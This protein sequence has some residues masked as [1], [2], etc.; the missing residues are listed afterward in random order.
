MGHGNLIVWQRPQSILALWSF[1]ISLI[2]D[3]L[4]GQV[5]STTAPLYLGGFFLSK[6]NEFEL[7][8]CVKSHENRNT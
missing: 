3:G 5:R 1:S 4:I 2:D 6:V 7:A 8:G